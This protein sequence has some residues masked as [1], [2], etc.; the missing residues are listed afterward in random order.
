MYR[1]LL[2]GQSY[3]TTGKIKNPEGSFSNGGAMRIA[4]IGLAFRH[5]TQTQHPQQQQQ[6]EKGEAV[7]LR[8]VV[9]ETLAASHVHP[10]AIDGATVVAFFVGRCALAP[11]PLEFDFL[12]VLKD[13]HNLCETEEMK[14]RLKM[15]EDF[16]E[17]EKKR[18]EEEDAKNVEERERTAEEIEKEDREMVSVLSSQWFQLRAVDAVAVVVYMFGRHGLPSRRRGGR[19]VVE[20]CGASVGEECLVR[21]VVLGGD[22]DTLA[23]MV[24]G[25]LGALYGFEEEDNW[26]PKRWIGQMENGDRGRDYV[27]SLAKSMADLDLRTIGSSLIDSADRLDALKTSLGVRKQ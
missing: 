13:A 18:N 17:K 6:K 16:F 4:P 12:E 11:S 21:V 7:S 26:L 14:K 22:T 25:M 1:A 19:C 10:E 3:R 24:G 8:D 23:C 15:I 5:L 2:A 27:I 20:C 9:A